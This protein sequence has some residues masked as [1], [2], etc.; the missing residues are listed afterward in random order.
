MK[1]FTR[2]EL[3]HVVAMAAVVV[4]TVHCG[5]SDTGNDEGIHPEFVGQGGLL[6]SDR[7]AL[8]VC[9]EVG[10]KYRD[11]AETM[12]KLVQEGLSVLQA[13]HESWKH[14]LF[15]PEPSVVLGCPAGV[16]PEG[17]LLPKD[18]VVGAG[19]TEHPS[20]YRLQIHVVGDAQA[21]AVLGERD[22]DRAIAEMMKIG[23]HV[24]AEVSSA[25]VVR[26]SAVEGE[27]LATR[28]LPIGLGLSPLVE[29]DQM[30]EVESEPKEVKEGVEAK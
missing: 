18:T 4:F 2:N 23:D 9:V 27:E 15:G 3:L 29:L 24:V 28:W 21:A 5:E 16:L 6:V 1:R 7:D 30:P 17:E 25:L 8:H 19:L 13:E 20:P 14:T 26:A 10:E 22:G 12:V 11:D